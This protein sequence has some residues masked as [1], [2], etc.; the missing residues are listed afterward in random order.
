[1]VSRMPEKVEWA[2]G[3]VAGNEIESCGEETFLR[4]ARSFRGQTLTRQIDRSFRKLS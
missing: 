2:T 3:Q 4:P 1:M